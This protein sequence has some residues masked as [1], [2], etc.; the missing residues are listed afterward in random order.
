M[1]ENSSHSNPPT[2][3][4]TGSAST[5]TFPKRSGDLTPEMRELE[6]QS[7]GIA[8]ESVLET[9]AEGRS[10]DEFCRSYHTQL[11]PARFRTWIYRDRNR[12]NA[13]LAAKAVGA[14]AVEDE[15][16]RISDGTLADGSASPDDVSRSQL[17][18]NTRKWLLQVWN[19]KRY[20]DVKTVESHSTTRFDVSSTSS[21]ELQRRVLES[22]GLDGAIASE[23]FAGEAAGG[24]ADDLLSGLFGGG[25][26][27]R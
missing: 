10:L 3:A 4:P 20:G 7:F 5:L 11:S 19:R 27:E 13:Y 9:L 22:L 2:G 8:F 26:H 23:E 17:R 14:E 1:S 24:E 12:R 21:A 16:I 15:L 18:I 6:L 25:E